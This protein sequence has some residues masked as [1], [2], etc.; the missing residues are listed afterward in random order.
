MTT[1]PQGEECCVFLIH[2]FPFVSAQGHLCAGNDVVAEFVMETTGF[3]SNFTTI[4]LTR[5]Q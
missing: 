3:I 4:P 1:V 2:V 5:C